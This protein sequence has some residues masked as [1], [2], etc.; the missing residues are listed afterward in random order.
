MMKW[1]KSVF[2]WKKINGH[3]VSES[4]DICRQLC[5]KKLQELERLS[6]D[7]FFIKYE[8]ELLLLTSTVNSNNVEVTIVFMYNRYIYMTCIHVM[9]GDYILKVSS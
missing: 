1:A 8:V 4:F 6:V 9:I 7:L 3:K 5:M 2:G